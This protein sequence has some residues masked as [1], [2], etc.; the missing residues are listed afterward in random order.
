MDPVIRSGCDSG[1]RNAV[2]ESTA[3]SHCKCRGDEK[4]G[5]E[6][7]ADDAGLRRDPESKAVWVER[8]F[9]AATLSAINARA[10]AFM[11]NS[12]RLSE[13]NGREDIP[14]AATIAQCRKGRCFRDYGS[15]ALVIV[16]GFT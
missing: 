16:F 15:T 6:K 7:R 10:N 4:A 5:E 14:H 13:R 2:R 11:R 3:P 1:T 9:A 8:L 12:I